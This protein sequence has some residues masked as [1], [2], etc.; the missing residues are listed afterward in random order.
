MEGKNP[1]VE[2]VTQTYPTGVKLTKKEM[3]KVEKKLNRLTNT[4]PDNQTNLGKWFVDII[5]NPG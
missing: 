4:D 5:Y 2:L 3:A 1:Q